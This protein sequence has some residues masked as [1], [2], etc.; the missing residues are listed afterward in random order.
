M[1][2]IERIQA[3]IQVKSIQIAH[4]DEEIKRME[5]FK[6]AVAEKIG[7]LQARE[8]ELRQELRERLGKA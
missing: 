8:E 1:P 7:F 4:I 5:V 6:Q 2:E 3:E